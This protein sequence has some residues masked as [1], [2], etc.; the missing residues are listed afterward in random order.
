MI[1]SSLISSFLYLFGSAPGNVHQDWL[2]G[3][4][5]LRGSE[6][7]AHATWAKVDDPDR[8]I[9]WANGNWLVGP[10]EKLGTQKKAVFMRWDP[11][12][13]PGKPKPLWTEL[14]RALGDDF[15]AVMQL[16][17]ADE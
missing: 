1:N 17:Y 6:V 5:L 13:E 15:K 3:Y 4:G 2:G 8:M 12:L 11:I 16:V 14:F 10:R 9:W 7:N